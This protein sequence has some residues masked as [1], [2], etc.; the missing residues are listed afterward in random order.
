MLWGSTGCP[1]KLAAFGADGKLID[2]SELP[3]VPGRKAPGDPVPNVELTVKGKQI[4]YIE[5]SG[6]R[7]GEFLVAEEL[8]Y[9]P[10]A[11]AAPATSGA[12]RKALSGNCGLTG[13]SR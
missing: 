1:A 9:V 12:N 2:K 10:D 13:G 4:A 7:V 6:P 11:A 5:F 8:R 3:A